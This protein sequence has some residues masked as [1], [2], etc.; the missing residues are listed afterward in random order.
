MAK[1][2][3]TFRGYGR[4]EFRG[5]VEDVQSLAD[6]MR[7]AMQQTVDTIV[8]HELDQEP[9]SFLCSEIVDLHPVERDEE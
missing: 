9:R 1:L 7:D 4:V 8:T 2:V 5:A 6:R 3:V